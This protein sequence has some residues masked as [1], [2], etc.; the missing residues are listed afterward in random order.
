MSK[1]KYIYIVQVTRQLSIDILNNF[2]KQGAEI[3]LVTGIVESNYAS[4]DSNV[5]VCYLNKYNSTSS[6]KRLFTWAIFTLRAFFFVLFKSKEYELILVTTPPFIIFVGSFFNKL[7][8]Q[9]FHLIIWDLYPDVLVNFGVLKESSFF[10]K[11]W[12]KANTKCF[13]RATHLFTLGKHLSDA[14][15]V[16]TN[17]L[18]ILIPNWTNTDFIKPLAKNENTFAIQHGLTSK[19]VVMYSGNLGI[20]H[21]IEAIV[22]TAEELKE[23]SAIQFVIIG[24]GAKKDK[25]TNMVKEKKLSNVLLL[26]YQDKEILP[27]SLSC[28][29]VGVVTLSEGAESISVPSKTYYMLAAGTAILAL[30][31]TNSELGLLINTYK[32]GKVFDNS[33]SKSTAEYILYLNQNKE[34]LNELKTNSRKASYD[35]TPTNATIYYDYICNQKV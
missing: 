19:F 35:Y 21:D 20:T 3:I 26:P 9:K 16:Y 2:S 17:K 13:N 33:Q 8:N 5:K 32:C 22:D 28:A 18:P 6:L 10:I 30:A 27:Y 14:I 11:R 24:E 29:D 1:K 7:R 23:Y 25:I 12:K 4:L 34:V 15:K 31:S